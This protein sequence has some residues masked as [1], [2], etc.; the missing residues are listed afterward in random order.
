MSG[1]LP[2]V[3]ASDTRLQAG[4]NHLASELAGGNA[5]EREERFETCSFQLPLAI[6]AHIFKEQIAKGNRLD[7]LVNGPFADRGHARLVILIRAGPRQRHRDQRQVDSAG[8]SLKNFLPYAV[9]GDTL[10]AL[11]HGGQQRANFE[12]LILP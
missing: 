10:K 3:D 7:A 2:R 6:G 4:G 8:L 1:N 5:P 11:V 12:L 9:H